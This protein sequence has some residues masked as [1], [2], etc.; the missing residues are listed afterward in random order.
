VLEQPDSQDCLADLKVR[1]D[2]LKLGIIAA[3]IAERDEGPETTTV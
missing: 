3:T 1:H 2:L